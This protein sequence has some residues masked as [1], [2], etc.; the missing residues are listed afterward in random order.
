MLC[1]GRQA[2]RHEMLSSPHPLPTVS[3]R[4]GGRDHHLTLYRCYGPV[5]STIRLCYITDCTCILRPYSQVATVSNPFPSCFVTFF[6][7][8]F[9]ILVCDRNS[10]IFCISP[11]PLYSNYRQFWLS[12]TGCSTCPGS[13]DLNFQVS[14]NISCHWSPTALAVPIIIC[15]YRYRIYDPI[16]FFMRYN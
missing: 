5:T 9:C 13:E 12:R 4:M 14:V 8:S 11:K 6:S 15:D 1:Y 2:Q 3:V 10:P 7:Y 16:T